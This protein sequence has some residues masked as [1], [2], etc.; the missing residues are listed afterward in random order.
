MSNISRRK[1]LRPTKEPLLEVYEEPHMLHPSILVGM[2]D[3]M[4]FFYKKA[5]KSFWVFEEIV[6]ELEKDKAD[7]IKLSEGQK[8]FILNILAFFAVSDFYVNE[9][10]AEQIKPRI[11]FLPWHRWEDYKLMMEN[12]H[13][14]TYGKL[15]EAYVPDKK[16][17]QEILTAVRFNPAIQHKINWM[18]KWV[19]KAN[20]LM[21]LDISKQNAIRDLYNAYVSEKLRSLEQLGNLDPTKSYTDAELNEIVQKYIP[22]N[23]RELVKEL[24]VEKPSL[25][26]VILINIIMEGIFFS[27]SFCAIFWFKKNGGLLPGLTMANDFIS[28]DEGLHTMFGIMIY[29]TKLKHHLQQNIVHDIMQEAVAIEKNFICNALPKGM[30][31]MNAQLMGR[32]IE[33]VADQQL[34]NLG[35][36]RIWTKG[37]SDNPFPWMENQSHGIR[38]ADFFKK[39]PNAYSHFASDLTADELKL[40]F[41][42][43]F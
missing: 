43:D 11:K 41:D 29:R 19:G 15:V 13:N 4:H 37:E 27:G 40:A 25:A 22:E 3:D 30:M 24:S 26:L 12:T 23:I 10:T 5:E 39:T 32:Y 8:F 20:E 34:T 7:W 18:H 21:H 17:R 42:E 38:I 36:E 14:F 9:T 16:Q 35:Y 1:M 6:K 33:F 28:R 2:D 31:G